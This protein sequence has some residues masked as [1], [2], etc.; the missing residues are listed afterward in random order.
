MIEHV[1][2]NGVNRQS[3]TLNRDQSKTQVMYYNTGM[4]NTVKLRMLAQSKNGLFAIGQS[5]TGT[6]MS[7]STMHYCT[8][9][10]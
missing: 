8:V 1:V 5:K 4:L 6:V 10:E 3:S 9:K 7:T 2:V